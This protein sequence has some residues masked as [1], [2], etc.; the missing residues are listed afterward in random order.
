MSLDLTATRDPFFAH[1]AETITVVPPSGESYE[2]EAVVDRDAVGPID[3]GD[4]TFVFRH[5]VAIRND[6]ETGIDGAALNTR[7]W[8][9][10]IPP[11]VGQEPKE[12]SIHRVLSQD[13]GV[14]TV[15][16]G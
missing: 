9:L 3:N 6:A 7:S 16:W 5:S 10:R 2:I 4:G 12:R 11:Q 14:I 1:F 15:E 13:A 8:R